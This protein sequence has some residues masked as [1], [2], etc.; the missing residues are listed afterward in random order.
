MPRTLTNFALASATCAAF[1]TV[2]RAGVMTATCAAGRSSETCVETSGS[3]E[4]TT[5]TATTLLLTPRSDPSLLT[6]HDDCTPHCSSH[7]NETPEFVFSASCVR[8]D[9]GRWDLLPQD[10]S[11]QALHVSASVSA[12]ECAPPAFAAALAH[13]EGASCEKLSTQPQG[14]EAISSR[15]ETCLF[16]SG[17]APEP[18]VLAMMLSLGVWIFLRKSASTMIPV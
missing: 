15:P 5:L 6:L 7:Q 14:T 4:R 18:A 11:F 8:A 1:T 12:V 13:N 9:A 17:S 2:A 16:S 3:V 10:S